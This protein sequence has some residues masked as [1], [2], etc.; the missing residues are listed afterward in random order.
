[1]ALTWQEKAPHFCGADENQPKSRGNSPEPEIT[2]D[3]LPMSTCNLDASRKTLKIN[4]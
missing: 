4:G 1:M 3:L 2:L